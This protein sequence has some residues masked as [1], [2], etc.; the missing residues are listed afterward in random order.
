[1]NIIQKDFIQ[2][3]LANRSKSSFN[4]RASNNS[5]LQIGNVSKVLNSSNKMEPMSLGPFNKT[6][7]EL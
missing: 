7:K 4:K 2:N 6:Q 5:T 1:M 3:K